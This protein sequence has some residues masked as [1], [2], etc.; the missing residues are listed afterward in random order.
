[1]RLY[2][3]GDIYWVDASGEGVSAHTPRQPFASRL[4]QRGA[5][6]ADIQ[7]LL[8]NKSITTT[9]RHAH[10]S[11]DNLSEAVAVL[12]ERPTPTLKTVK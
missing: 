11:T 2:K 8:G 5:N 3:R 9:G 4:V 6:L 12:E 10:I 7:A 1:M